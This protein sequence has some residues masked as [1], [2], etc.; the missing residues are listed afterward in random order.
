MKKQNGTELKER[1]EE[2]LKEGNHDFSQMEI[3]KLIET[4]NVY[5]VELEYQNEEL[6]RIQLDLEKAKARFTSLFENAPVG[7]VLCNNDLV[8]ESANNTFCCMLQCDRSDEELKITDYIHPDSQ[9]RFYLFYRKLQNTREPGSLELEITGKER[10]IPVNLEANIFRDNGSQFIRLAIMDLT[11]QKENER[12]LE[13]KTAEL[14]ER[15]KELNCLINVSHLIDDPGKSEEEIPVSWQYPES[16]AAR[17]ILGNQIFE[18]SGFKETQWQLSVPILRDKDVAGSIMVCYISDVPVIEGDVFLKEE[19]DLLESISRMIGRFLDRKYFETQLTEREENLRIT[20]NSIGDGVIA[21]DL[22]GCITNLNPI[23][24]ELTGWKIA[25]AAGKPVTEVFDIVHAYTGDRAENPIEKVL[26]KGMIVGLANHTKLIAK[27]GREF[28]IADSAAPIRDDHNDITGVVMVFRDVTESYRMRE[29]LKLSEKQLRKAQAISHTGSWQFFLD[30]GKIKASDEAYRLYGLDEDGEFSIPDV[31][32]CPLPEYREM[33]DRAMK[34]LIQ[35]KE[36]YDVEF[37]VGRPDGSVIDVHSVAEY[38]A[39]EHTVTGFIQ[40]IT[41]RKSA[42]RTL[43]ERERYYRSMLHSLHEDIIVIGPDYRILDI[44]NSALKTVGL[45][46]D[47]VVGKFCYEVTH[48]TE[49]PCHLSGESCALK[50]VFKTGESVNLHHLHYNEDGSRLHL[51]LLCSP[52]IDGNGKVTHMI[53]AARDVT[54]LFEAQMEIARSEEKF[55]NLFKKHSAIKIILDPQNGDILEANDAAAAFYGW[56]IR[57]L[58]KMNISQISVLSRKEVDTRLKSLSEGYRS[59]F[60]SRHRKA[61]D[62]IRDVEI[63]G[64]HIDIGDKVILHVVIHDIT[65]K[66]HAEQQL[67][68]LSQSVEQNPVVIVITDHDGNIQYVNPAFT[69]ITGYTLD[70]VMGNNPRILQ[71]G[72][73]SEEFYQQLWD[74]I[75]SGESWKGTMRNKKKNGAYYWEEAIIS[76]I[77]DEQGEITHFVAV[78]EDI[79][80]R[81]QLMEDLVVAKEKAE[82]SDRL[83]SAFLANMSHEIRTPMNGILGFT[84]LLRNPDLSSE[85]V[86]KYIEIIHLSGQRM[87]N[88]VNDIVEISKIEAGIVSIDYEE[89]NIK[90]RVEEIV[91]FFYPEAKEKGITLTLDHQDFDDTVVITTDLRKF[92]AIFINLLK[93]AV[94]FTEKGEIRVGCASRASFVE[95]YVKDSGIG[96][97]KNMHEAVFRRF[98]QADSSRTRNFEG[99]GLGLAISKSYIELLGGSIRVESEE[100]VGSTFYFTLPLDPGSGKKSPVSKKSR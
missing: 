40:D 78:K 6:R 67:K 9:D 52:M 29:E 17:I 99:S 50:Q 24:E 57:E 92:D 71:S 44:N 100:G 1:I 77:Q 83:K 31:Q 59:H 14:G 13:E 76:P 74:T 90:E 97:P 8:I 27:D 96:I 5:H 64:S 34:N 28:Q 81:K 98:E 12:K 36:K 33:L 86:E 20:L 16:A 4:V 70:E 32:K 22:K 87:L 30:T 18:N 69:E 11:R 7:Y 39:K 51:D 19:Y 72:Y 53:E 61:D 73:Q 58:E 46:R 62:T 60:E 56:S 41:E 95:F 21:T 75:L 93:N 42:E 82:E 26:E 10:V 2:V 37:Q 55:R 94:K 85:K 79:T 43:K 91:R 66:K 63:F 65:D 68:L 48:H 23:A 54:D 89:G 49:K 88:T 38:N 47:E 45:Q 35:G 3:N 80:E 15:V 25:E 84:G